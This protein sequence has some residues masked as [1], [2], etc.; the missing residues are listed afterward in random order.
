MMVVYTQ[1]VMAHIE[2]MAIVVLLEG[3]REFAVTLM[4]PV[5]VCK[6]VS[7]IIFFFF[8]FNC[9][10]LVYFSFFQV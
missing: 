1:E 2:D 3:F 7:L 4:C 10:C 6:S 8:V 5:C 9:Q